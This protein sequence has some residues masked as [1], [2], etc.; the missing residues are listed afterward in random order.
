MYIL[1]TLTLE[2]CTLFTIA[3]LI[4]TLIVPKYLRL[5]KLVKN[6]PDSVGMTLF[7]LLQLLNQVRPCLQLAHYMTDVMLL[8]FQKLQVFLHLTHHM[9][10]RY[11]VLHAPMLPADVSEDAAKSGHVYSWHI[12]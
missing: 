12:K 9:P 7:S 11:N 10:I 2:L 3:L 4:T 1:I 5:T 8:H 6:M